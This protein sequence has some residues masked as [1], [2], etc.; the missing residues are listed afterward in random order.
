MTS[1]RGIWMGL[2]AI[3]LA[4]GIWAG[5]ALSGDMEEDAAD[6]RWLS[7][8]ASDVEFESLEGEPVSIREYAGEVILLNFWGTWCPPCRKEI[9]ELV[10]LQDAFE[11]RGAIVVGIAVDSGRPDDIRAFADEFGVNYPI[12]VSGARKALAHYDAVG[13]PFTVLIDREGVIR[14]QYLGPQ[15]FETLAR[16]MEAFL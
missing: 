14:K 5:L 10:E 8:P 1:N 3:L 13:Y 15:S 6:G 2:G 12:W 16:D 9:P 4:G 7:I 11:G